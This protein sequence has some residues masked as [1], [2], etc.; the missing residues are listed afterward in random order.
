MPVLRL[1]I[2][3]PLRQ[4]KVLGYWYNGAFARYTVVPGPAPPP[5]PARSA[6]A[7]AR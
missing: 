1:G 3:Q 6:S 5:L 7:R 2:L 4:R